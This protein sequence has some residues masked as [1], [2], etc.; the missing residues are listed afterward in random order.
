M[1]ESRAVQ[2]TATNRAHGDSFATDRSPTSDSNGLVFDLMALAPRAVAPAAEPSKPSTTDQS[3]PAVKAVLSPLLETATDQS[4][5]AS[6]PS[7]TDLVSISV[8]ALVAMDSAAKRGLETKAF[9]PKPETTWTISVLPGSLKPVVDAAAMTLSTSV[10]NLLAQTPEVSADLQVTDLPDAALPVAEVPVP[11]LSANASL[12]ASPSSHADSEALQAASTVNVDSK[13]PQPAVIS[14]DATKNL[15]ETVTDPNTQPSQSVLLS[16]IEPAPSAA[17][18]ALTPSGADAVPVTTDAKEPD[19]DATAHR[20][21][22]KSSTVSPDENAVTPLDPT[23]G[24][25]ILLPNEFIQPTPTSAQTVDAAQEAVTD[26]K[27]ILLDQEGKKVARQQRPLRDSLPNLSPVI[28]VNTPRPSALQNGEAQP[29]LLPKASPLPGR[30]NPPSRDASVEPDALLAASWEA[31]GAIGADNQKQQASNQSHSGGAPQP[32]S[33]S[34]A[35]RFDRRMDGSSPLTDHAG[36]Q[37]D[38]STSSAVMISMKELPAEIT[39]ESISI[40]AAE[41]TDNRKDPSAST[42]TAPST[43]PSTM[44]VFAEADHAGGVI[45][46]TTNFRSSEQNGSAPVIQSNSA[47]AASTAMRADNAG[48]IAQRDR[49]MEQQIISALRNG[50]DE[51]RFSLYPATLG[52]VTINLALDGQKVRIGMKTTNREAST[53]LLGERQSLVASLGQEGFTLDGFDVTDDAT[54][55]PTSKDQPQN[56]PSKATLRASDDSFSLDITI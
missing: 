38:Q 41:N 35:D 33:Q 29:N 4:I 43:T 40:N 30:V 5:S 7:E 44:A 11:D 13:A 54:R 37:I 26:N 24:T 10:P 3:A 39:V 9:I 32:S 16:T 48:F 1:I 56:H 49:A 36:A 21:G 19:K 45:I 51:I 27:E 18:L 47:S 46:D 34:G 20:V 14:P 6:L 8:D 28:P 31:K 17:E 52:Q 23:L 50:R 42:V 15:T 12:I 25:G 55:D 53:V 2:T 22:E